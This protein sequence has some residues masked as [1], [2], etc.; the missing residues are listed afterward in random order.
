M[1]K[2]SLKALCAVACL[3][4][5]A[6]A[7][8]GVLAPADYK[9]AKADINAKYKLDRTACNATAGNAKDICKEEA[10][11]RKTIAKAELVDRDEPTEAHHYG[12]RLAKAHAAFSVAKEKCDDLSG[13]PKDVCRKEANAAYV[14]AK[15]DAKLAEKTADVNAA[16][17]T[18]KAD[19]RQDAAATKLKANYAVAREKCDALAGDPKATCLRDA[20]SLYGQP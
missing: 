11:G 10:K 19:A 8:A 20:K 12:V 7:N 4:A 14:T 9:A 3:T 13:N 6:A 2:R 15:T 5:S 18:E 17:S 1:N 16:A